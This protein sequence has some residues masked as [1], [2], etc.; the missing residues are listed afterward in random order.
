MTQSTHNTPLLHRAITL[1]RGCLVALL[2]LPGTGLALVAAACG[3]LDVSPAIAVDA[4]VAQGDVIDAPGPSP[5]VAPVNEP[6]KIAE[7]KAPVVP[8]L[9]PLD[10]A[11]PTIK[12]P[13]PEPTEEAAGGLSVVESALAHGVSQRRPVRPVTEF[14]VGD[15][16]WA[17]ISLKNSGDRQP[18]TM[19]WTQDGQIRSR[20]TLEVGT[21]PRWRTWSR[22]TMRASDVGDWRVEVQD[23][24]GQVLHTMRFKVTPQ[25]ET[26]T[27]ADSPFDG[28]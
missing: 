18:A 4:Q 23:A 16:A 6:T 28:C 1:V 19:V 5:M 22:R 24:Q 3:D 14:Q 7:A 10:E 9:L 21:S 11:L 20:L 12:A 27:Y 13:E 17:W 15:V 8:T 25:A 2:M 26:V